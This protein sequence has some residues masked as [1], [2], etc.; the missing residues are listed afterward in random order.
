MER[1]DLLECV[2]RTIRSIEPDAQIILYGSQSRLDSTPESDWDLLVLVGGPV[3]DDRTDR[4]RHLLY[5][6]EWESGHVISAII[7]NHERWNSHP[8][9]STLFYENIKRDGMEL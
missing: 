4:I 2:K 3:D 1:Q 5:E 9:S 8:Y 6:I 7:R